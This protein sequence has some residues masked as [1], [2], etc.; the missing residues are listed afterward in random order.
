MKKLSRMKSLDYYLKNRV[1]KHF[2]RLCYFE[3]EENKLNIKDAVQ[4]SEDEGFEIFS[5]TEYLKQD[6]IRHEDV[7]EFKIISCMC[8]VYH[9]KDGKKTMLVVCKWLEEGEEVKMLFKLS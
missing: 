2:A 5:H 1:D 4:I 8:C 9:L 6:V 3:I 7:Y